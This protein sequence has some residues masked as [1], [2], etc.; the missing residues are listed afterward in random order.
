[1]LWGSSVVDTEV[2][3]AYTGIFSTGDASYEGM[4]TVI[5]LVTDVVH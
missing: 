4:Y 2:G 1:M 3:A 5:V